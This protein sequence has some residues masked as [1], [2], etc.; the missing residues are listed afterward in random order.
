MENR[1]YGILK[2]FKESV[3]KLF[4]LNKDMGTF[5]SITTDI[6]KALGD[7]EEYDPLFTAIIKGHLIVE[8][9]L[10]DLLINFGFSE[11]ILSNR[12]FN[13]W[14]KFKLCEELSLIDKE[15][16]PPIAKLN[17]IRNKYGHNIGFKIEKKIFR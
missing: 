8:N 13:F 2:D 9:H 15:H 12:N 7:F 11:E 4:E 17:N 10:E 5:D 16:V 6:N 3:N 14:L 1:G